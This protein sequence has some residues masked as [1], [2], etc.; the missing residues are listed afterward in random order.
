MHMGVRLDEYPDEVRTLITGADEVHVE[1]A[2]L[3]H[4]LNSVRLNLAVL[5][6][7][8]AGNVTRLEPQHRAELERRLGSAAAGAEGL[9]PYVVCVM[10][11][12]AEFDDTPGR[13]DE[14]VVRAARTAGRPIRNLD[15]VATQ[16]EAM[17]NICTLDELRQQLETTG[18]AGPEVGDPT[19]DAFRQGDAEWLARTSDEWLR[20]FSPERRR[21][22]L[23]VMFTRRNEAWTE[24]LAGVLDERSLFVAVGALHLV[25]PDNIVELLRAR[26]FTVER[27]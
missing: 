18:E 20:A 2:D 19:V 7:V 13:L 1:N 25:G 24:H 17:K 21:L 9:P 12:Q 14:E 8:L 23:E 26:G 4:P 15:S 11:I 6:D 3:S 16:I 22:I 27:I 10:L 5:K